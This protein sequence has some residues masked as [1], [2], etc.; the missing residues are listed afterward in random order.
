MI[1][2]VTHLPEGPGGRL[3]A[4]VALILVLVLCGGFYL[5]Y[6]LG[7]G[8]IDLARQQQD[9]VSAVSHELKTP[10]TSI[11]MYGEMLR[12]GWAPEEKKKSYY[13]FIHDESERLSRL[14]NNVLQLA[15]MTRNEVRVD[16]KPV[17]VAELVDGIRS[18]VSS[19]DRACRLSP[20]PGVRPGRCRERRRGGSRRLHPDR[21]QSG[22]QRSQVLRQVRA[23]RSSTSP[24]ECRE[25]TGCCSASETTVPGYRGTR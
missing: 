15:R 23:P 10:L 22:G 7:A 9:F 4:W 24:A 12:E 14:I 16:I 1:F 6:R 13:E 25:V 19:P 11:R 8:Q 5:L 3:V 21:H 17:E 2:S 20:Q 18:R